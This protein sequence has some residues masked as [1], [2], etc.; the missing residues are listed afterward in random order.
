MAAEFERARAQLADEIEFDLLLGGINTH[1]TQP[2]GDYGRR[3]LLRLWREVEETTGQKFAYRFPDEYVHNSTLPCVAIEAVR[4][5]S[6]EVPFDYLHKLQTQFFLYARD[7]NDRG[8]LLDMAAQSG[9]PATDLEPL[10]DD[11]AL[12]ER[13]RFQF[14]HAGSFGT[15]ALPSL[16]WQAHPTAELQLFAGGY[17]DAQMLVELVRN[18]PTMR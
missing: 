7:L 8:L 14:N 5:L 2:I 15:Q 12:L 1:G 10:L 16:L 11:S 18:H 3:Y 6:G 17:V 9:V 4:M 13:V